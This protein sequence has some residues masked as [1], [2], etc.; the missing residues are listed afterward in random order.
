MN[1]IILGA[2]AIGS[3]FGAFL[4]KNNNVLLIGRPPH[5]KA[6]QTNGLSITG[7]TNTKVN[8]NAQTT[9]KHLPFQP[10][11]LLLTVKSY[12]TASAIKQAQSILKDDTIICSLQNG[13]DNIETIKN[14]LPHHHLTVGITTHGAFFQK[15]GV[16]KHTGIGKTIIG[17]I[18]KQRTEQ[19]LTLTDILNRATIQTTISSDIMKDLWKKAII[20]SS[21]NPITTIF[22]CKNGY[23]LTNPIL[24][25]I[26]ERICRESTLIAQLHGIRLSSPQLIKETKMVIKNTAEN[27]S[28]MLQSIQQGKKT[29]IN[30]IN[31]RL[32][33]IGKKHHATT[34]LNEIVTA[35]VKTLEKQ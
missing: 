35:L 2:G 20:N 14:I 3:L 23:L 22:Q 10:D 17:E 18:K 27:Y 9:L 33:E 25:N 7:K 34:H 29:E 1:I 5:V 11:I 26:T 16:I 6:I 4:S 32:I 13:L 30:S 12:D 28:S 24:E 31:G 21:I 15:P 19:V 8:I